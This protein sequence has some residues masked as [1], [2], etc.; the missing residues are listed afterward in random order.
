ML[1]FSQKHFLSKMRMRCYEYLYGN[2]QGHLQ[3]QSS[4]YLFDIAFAIK[5]FSFRGAFFKRILAWERGISKSS[6]RNEVVPFLVIFHLPYSKCS[7]VKICFYSCLYQNQNFS[8]V[9]HWGRSCSARVALVPLVRHSCR[10]CVAPVLLISH[11]CHS[12]LAVMA[13]VN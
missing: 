12:C 5:K 4:V 1:V 9:L 7:G 2:V 10:T 11:S 8:L 13:V 3:L 6:S